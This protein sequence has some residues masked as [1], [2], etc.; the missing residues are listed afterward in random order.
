MKEREGGKNK[1]NRGEETP[2]EAAGAAVCLGPKL[3][4]ARTQ[5]GGKSWQDCISRHDPRST[6]CTIQPKSLR[7]P[8]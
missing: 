6:P 8:K 1:S 3:I 7:Q 5:S 2:K 4:D